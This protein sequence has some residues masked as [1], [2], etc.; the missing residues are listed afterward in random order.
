[1]HY[2]FIGNFYRMLYKLT[3]LL[4]LTAVAGS[5]FNKAII[6]LDYSMNK[7]FIASQL[8]ENRNKPMSCCQGKCYL[9]KQLQQD[10]EGKNKQA[11]ARGEISIEWFC[12]EVSFKCEIPFDN[13]LFFR[14]Y[15]LKHYSILLPSVFHPPG[16]A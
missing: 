3:A 4:L 6:L 12:E 5:T 13:N 15:L 16:M 10:Q 2:N 8:C 11:T 9:K 7:N 1:L 14:N